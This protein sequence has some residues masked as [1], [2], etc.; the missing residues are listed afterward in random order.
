MMHC[1]HCNKPLDRCRCPDLEGRL[2]ELV[3]PLAELIAVAIHPP[4]QQ[5]IESKAAPADLMP[6]CN[7][8]AQ[9]GVS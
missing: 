6:W 5:A 8:H 9:G 7:V 2:S 4:A 3:P 1:T